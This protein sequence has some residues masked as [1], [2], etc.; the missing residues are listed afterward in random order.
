MVGK[1]F[2]PEARFEINRTNMTRAATAKSTCENILWNGKTD[3]TRTS[4]DVR[5]LRE[6]TKT[7]KEQIKIFGICIACLRGCV[8]YNLVQ[9][10]LHC[11]KGVFENPVPCGVGHQA[12][13]ADIMK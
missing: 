6:N 11:V 8:H 4:L 13:G 1:V 9:L 7:E 3:E 2:G 10:F 12:L 5:L